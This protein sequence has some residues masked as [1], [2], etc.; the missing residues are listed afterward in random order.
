MFDR[1]FKRPY[2]A[3]RHINAP[4]LKERTQYLQQHLD[5]GCAIP[6][7]QDTAQHLLMIIELLDLRPGSVISFQEIEQ[8][9]DKWTRSQS[10]HPMKRK[11]FSEHAKK[12]FTFH[13]IQWLKMMNCLAV[14]EDA[15]LLMEIFDRGAAIKRHTTSLLL[16]ERLLYLQYWSENGACKDTLR[17]IGQYLLVIMN[18]LDFYTL[19]TVTEPEVKEASERWLRSE[20][21]NKKKSLHSKCSK[22]HF[23]RNAS[24]WLE[25]L[26]CYEKTVDKPIPFGEYL[27][28][29]IVYMRTEQGL[30]ESTIRGSFFQLKDFLT[31]IAEQ[32]KNFADIIPL[33]IDNI[34]IKK[35]DHNGY[36]RKSIQGYATVIRSFLK[37]AEE[38]G[39]CQKNLAQSIKTPRVYKHE[40]LPYS[41]SWEDVKKILANNKTDYPTDIRNYAIL[42][43]LSVYGM[44][45]SEVKKLRLEDIDWRNELLHV[46]RAKTAKP[47]IFPLSKRVGEAILNYLK[48]VRPNHCS[49]RE[50]FLCRLAPYRPLTS[51]CIYQIVSR[52]MIPLNLNIKHHGPHALRHACATHLINSGITLKEISDHLGH[53]HLDST[54]IYAKVDLVNLRKV[55]DLNLGDLL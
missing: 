43:L 48:N 50:V 55:A 44:R 3:N 54:G 26:G 19:R 12:R 17:K 49:L 9:A 24:G 8:A 42:M 1:L 34:L 33:T 27:T 22:D 52:N 29:Y 47:Q 45:C 20:S 46:R 31:N 51:S 21:I 23:I 2:Y 40:S 7:V 53:Q 28:Q 25:M 39:W 11:P 4:F 37:F 15:S 38:K 30:S 13:A 5:R 18:C 6:F 36:C 35:C 32:K 14:P 41:P 10:K 16:K